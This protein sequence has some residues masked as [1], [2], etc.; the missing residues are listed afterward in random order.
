M[1]TVFEKLASRS[2][3]VVAALVAVTALLAIPFLAMVPE[4]SASTEPGGAVFDARDQVD[5]RFVSSVRQVGFV[6]AHDSG[7]LLAAEPLR[8]LL[9]AQ[10]RLQNDAELGPTLFTYFDTDSGLEVNGIASIADLVDRDLRGQGASLGIA[11]DTQVQAVIAD[12]IDTYGVDSTVLGLSQLTTRDAD[13]N[14]VAPA[15]NLG[16]AADD[17]KL[18]FGNT[19]VNLGGDTDSE[20]YDRD[21]Q[22][23]L[24]TAADWSVYGIA[25]DVNLTSQEQGAVAGPFI[26]FTVLAAL[27]LVGLTFR[28]YWIMATVSVMFLLLVV[29]LK[30]LSNL[31]GFK[32]DLVLSLIV[33][34]AMVSF[35]VDYAFHALG[36]YREERAA[37]R[38]SR[39]AVVTGAAGVSGALV[40]ATASDSVAFLANTTAGIESIVQFGIGAAIALFGAYVLL[41]VVSPILVGWIEGAVPP[42]TP[43]LRSGLLRSAAAVGAA[44]MAMASVLFLVFVLPWLGLVLSVVTA[45]VTL[46][47]PAWWRSRRN[48]GVAVGDVAL[49]AGESGLARRIGA[50]VSAIARRRLIVLPVAFGVSV[51]AAF[52]ALQVP[53]EF[54]VED[55]F[56]A[57]TDFVEGLDLIDQHLGDRGGE[58]ATF[59][60]EGELTNPATLATLAERVD[61]ISELETSSLARVDGEVGLRAGIFEVFA[62]TWESPSMVSVVEAQTGVRLSDIDSDGVPDTAQQVEAL[63]ATARQT[64]VPFDESRLAL[65]PDDVAV[66]V[67]LGG[68]GRPDATVFELEI[69]DSRSQTSVAAARDVLD[70]IAD[71]ISDDLGGTF[72]QVTGSA[73]VREASLEGTNRALSVSLP[74]AIVACLIVASTFLRSIRF[75]LASVMPILMVV[76]W[77][78]AFMYLAGFAINLVTATIAAVSIGIGIDF[79]LHYIARYREELERH[80]NREI[81]V[82]IAG[83]GTGLAL[84]ASAFSSAVGFGILAFAPMPLFAS[85]GLL[86]AI[87]IMMALTATLVVLPSLLMVITPTDATVEPVVLRAEGEREAQVNRGAPVLVG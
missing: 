24:R 30:G 2:R 69:V 52:F 77:L 44:M 45:L 79:A 57:D 28:S 40:L 65:T 16:L 73:F 82:R 62:A 8:E 36:R 38:P 59:Y 83:E 67:D 6:A 33:P 9:G 68:E 43:G 53:A 11:T 10:E 55:F 76:A 4:E 35:G 32:D 3:L 47:L 34:I 61:E 50:V 25:I 13:G 58:P 66:A 19:A 80:R 18:G 84:V 29:W 12:L 51:A 5:E 23:V 39:V 17:T 60:I 64:G 86:T 63:I 49:A 54:D 7:N 74:I 15:I 26:G 27:L 46:V 1:S 70:P 41:G 20:E 31:I 37:G 48:N 78:Y 56:A 14:W 22:E 42:P 21:L 71:A 87:M 75:G 85:Y 72:V 81:A